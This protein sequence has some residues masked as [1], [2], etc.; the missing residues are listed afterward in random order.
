M[1]LQ[2][3]YFRHWLEMRYR[4]ISAAVIA[5]VT[6]L[7]YAVAIYGTLDYYREYGKFADEVRGA[8]HLLPRMGPERL[9]VWGV[10]VQ[11][12]SIAIMVAI[13]ALADWTRIDAWTLS[14][15]ISRTRIYATRLLVSATGIFATSLLICA[16]HI[17]TLALVG[18]PIP[19]VEML[20]TTFVV[21]ILALPV[22]A[23]KT[24]LMMNGILTL[25][26]TITLPLLVVN[27]GWPA[28][29]NLLFH[30]DQAWL[31]AAIALP[32]TAIFFMASQWFARRRD[33]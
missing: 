7:L 3:I 20:A 27:F 32:L 26:F 28:L 15:P 31:A 4:L 22:F 23:L 12:L 30:P 16:I 33:V 6:G 17:A 25:L 9:I 19:W 10:H 18:D 24:M 21:S 5:I 13:A 2:P 11:L 8:V 14:L 29:R 1:T